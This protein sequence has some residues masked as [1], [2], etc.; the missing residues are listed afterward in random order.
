MTTLNRVIHQSASKN[1]VNIKKKK[2][3]I[4]FVGKLN[5]SKGYDLFGESIIK[6]LDKYKDWSAIVVGDEPKSVMSVLFSRST[7]SY[8]CH[9]KALIVLGK[10]ENIPQPFQFEHG[11]NILDGPLYPWQEILNPPMYFPLEN[12]PVLKCYYE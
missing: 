1:K 2:K 5:K 9:C 4:T 8:E 3:I 11:R 10:S 12:P 6:I 7:T